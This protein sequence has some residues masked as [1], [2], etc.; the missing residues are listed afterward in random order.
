MGT[1][2]YDDYASRFMREARPDILSMDHYPV[3]R[4]DRD[5][6]DAYLANLETMRREAASAGVPFWNFFNTMPY[7]PHSDPTEAQLRWQINASIASGA[8]GV[9]YFCYW[10]PGK[11]AAGAG[12]F[13]KGGAIITA[14]GL[15]THHY[16]EARRLNAVVE[17]LGPTLMRLSGQGVVRVHATTATNNLP[18]G[19]AVR[20]LSILPHDPSA[21]FL[22]GS[23]RHRDGRRAVILVNHSLAYGVW[24]T[25][26]FDAPWESVRELDPATGAEIIPLDNSPELPG[27]QCALDAGAARTFLL[28]NQS[29]TGR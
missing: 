22:L 26:T 27:F 24:P 6:R 2:S 13:P 11:G 1:A 4:P 9:L 17:K 16:D 25:L 14:E 8:K 18:P 10:T 3:M 29:T 21:D 7:G 20:T 5:S 28:P 23:F 15:R 19:G 12:E